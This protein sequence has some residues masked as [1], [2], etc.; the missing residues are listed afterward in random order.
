MLTGNTGSGVNAQTNA[1]AIATGN[2]A[3]NNTAGDFTN[4]GNYPIDFD[5]YTTAGT[6]ANEYVD[7]TNLNFQIKYGSAVWGKGYGV[8]DQIPTGGGLVGRL[9]DSNNLVA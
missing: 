8:S 5:N 2:R 3:R 6:D 9:V 1:R 7:A 4:F